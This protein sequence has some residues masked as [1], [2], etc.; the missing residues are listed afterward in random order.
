MT[1]PFDRKAKAL[2]SERALPGDNW[3]VRRVQ[4]FESLKPSINT[5]ATTFHDIGRLFLNGEI[6]TNLR[7]ESLIDLH[8]TRPAESIGHLS[9][10]VIPSLREGIPQHVPEGLG[11]SWTPDVAMQLNIHINDTYQRAIP[12]KPSP[13]GEVSLYV[14]AKTWGH[15]TAEEKAPVNGLTNTWAETGDQ[16]HS[17]S[18]SQIISTL[19][20]SEQITRE[21]TEAILAPLVSH[22]I[23][24]FDLVGRPDLKQFQEPGNFSSHLA[25]EVTL[26]REQT[27]PEYIALPPEHQPELP[28]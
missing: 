3:Y 15:L 4:G 26:F 9:L 7:A 14:S 6:S 5:I 11:Y 23:D 27:M 24:Y 17:R 8:N 2:A 19:G 1:S 25:P 22:V 16:G 21:K 13:T 12:G 10:S 28:Q 20:T 18:G